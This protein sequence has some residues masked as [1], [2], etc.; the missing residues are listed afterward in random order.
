MS[1]KGSF[2]GITASTAYDVKLYY[3]YYQSE[4]SSFEAI[5]NRIHPHQVQSAPGNSD[6]I[7]RCGGFATADAS[8]TTPASLDDY[9]AELDFTL[10]HRTSYVRFSVSASD[11]DYSGWL[12]KRIGMAAPEGTFIAGQ[13][14]WATTTGA[15]S[16]ENTD[17]RSNAVELDIDNA[18]ALGS[19]PQDAYMVVFPVEVKG[20]TITFTYTLQ[21]PD[22]SR[23]V[24]LARNKTMSASSTLFAPGKL[25]RLEEVLPST[26]GGEWTVS[27]QNWDESSLRDKILGIAKRAGVPSISVAYKDNLHDITLSVV[28]DDFYSRPGISTDPNPITENTVYQAASVTKV[29]FNYIFWKMYEEG[30]FSDLDQPVYEL[31]PDMLDLFADDAQE[32]A[33]LITLRMILTHTTGLDGSLSY[34]TKFT[35]DASSSG[36]YPGGNKYRYS[37]RGISILGW[38]ME[39]LKGYNKGEGLIQMGRDYIF[40]RLGMTNTNFGWVDSY[41]TLACKGYFSNSWSKNPGWSGGKVNAAYSLRSNAKEYNKY[42]QWMMRGA[43]L[44]PET[45]DL[46]FTPQFLVTSAKSGC[47]TEG[48]RTLGW[49]VERNEELG[50]VYRHSGSLDGFRSEACMIPERNATFCIFTNHN[51]VYEVREA[52]F[53]L[54]LPKKD[55]FSWT[56]LPGVPNTDAGAGTSPIVVE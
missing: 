27:E 48:W 39:H 54:F 4:A 6:H 42:L 41:E 10:T 31:W 49:M 21:K 26:A 29:T 24:T 55:G 52:V 45:L 3:P 17:A 19:T 12:L 44:A 37:N 23:T 51:L 1:F 35:F 22:G 9:T 13:T 46:M 5:R 47:T 28:N 43:D 7:G 2:T 15:F 56:S 53:N 40:D 34:N 38:T 36:Y 16:L 8:F 50:P 32:T 14:S 30:Y 20:K 18:E 11:G 25:Y 33:K